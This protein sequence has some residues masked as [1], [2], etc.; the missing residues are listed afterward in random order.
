MND[1]EVQ[2]HQIIL[3]SIRKYQRKKIKFKKGKVKM[4]G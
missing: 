2:K 4:A 3:S 1:L